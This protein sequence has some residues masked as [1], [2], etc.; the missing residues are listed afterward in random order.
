[1][2]KAKL[3]VL[4]L[5]CLSSVP[6]AAQSSTVDFGRDVQPILRENCYGCHGPSQQIRGI[7]VDQR[8]SLMP[9]RR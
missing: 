2:G 3:A 4:L 1:V 6:L 9:N 5:V 7:R 8:R